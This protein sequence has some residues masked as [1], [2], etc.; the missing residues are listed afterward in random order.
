MAPLAGDVLTA[1]PTTPTAPLDRQ[2]EAVEHSRSDFRHLTPSPYRCAKR[3]AQPRSDTDALCPD[4]E[5]GMI[6]GLPDG[7]RETRTRA[8]PCSPI[9]RVVDERVIVDRA[10]ATRTS[11]RSKQRPYRRGGWGRVSGDPPAM[12]SS[13]GSP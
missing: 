9:M 10:R 11:G 1:A 7:A 12:H 13:V 5:G 3:R 2:S 8:Q 6:N 4:H